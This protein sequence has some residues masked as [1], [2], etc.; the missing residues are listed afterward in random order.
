MDMQRLE[1]SR[2]LRDLLKAFLSHDV[3]FLVIG[4]HAVS[5][6]GYPRF[7]KDLDIWVELSAGNATRI[8][9]ALKS[10]GL[11]FP[12]LN[13]DMFLDPDRMTQM[14]REPNRVDILMKIRGVDF[15]ACYERKEFVNIDGSL[16]PMISKVDL[17]INKRSTGRLQDLADIENI[18]P[19]PGL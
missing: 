7:T 13:E 16:I 19:A 3:R 8:V 5:F 17:I 12:G 9:S 14:G 6:H 18:T 10:F 1:L 15:G 2:D 11:D 4:G